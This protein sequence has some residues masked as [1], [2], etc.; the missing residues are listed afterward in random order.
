M[1][2]FIKACGA[3]FVVAGMIGFAI[4]LLF[5]IVGGAGGIIVGLSAVLGAAGVTLIGGTAYMLCKIDERLEGIGWTRSQNTAG[6][7]AIE[8]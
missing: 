6:S 3:L 2:G 8:M 7:R 4:A 5:A 1:R